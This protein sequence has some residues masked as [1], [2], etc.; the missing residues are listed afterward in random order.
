MDFNHTIFMKPTHLSLLFLIGFAFAV[1][2]QD[3]QG[4]P[5]D[6]SKPTVTDGAGSG[7]GEGLP[8]PMAIRFVPPPPPKPIPPIDVKAQSVKRLPSHRITV[9]RGEPSTLPDIPQL[10]PPAKAPVMMEFVS[11]PS[12]YLIPLSATIYNQSL[13]H[14]TWRNVKTGESFEA[15]CGW[16]FS[17]LAPMHTLKGQDAI[18]SLF[19]SPQHIDT[20]KPDRF[21]KRT[22]IP[23]HPLVPEED[24]ILIGGGGRS[25][26]GGELIEALQQFYHV[27]KTRLEQI[28]IARKQYRKES[29]AWHKANPRK[30]QDH[31]IWLKPH[32]G[33][34]YLAGGTGAGG[35][36]APET[37]T[38]EDAQ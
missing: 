19:F 4:P 8:D 2:A 24:Y 27:H 15:W 28:R 17:L 29:A 22:R 23:A 31:T 18:Y 35:E 9:L 7:A 13:S 38:G 10:T 37:T 20:T 30:P 11:Q 32:R 21:G 36:S 33:S 12:H 5:A 6:D 16:D 26:A 14:L 1:G 25:P 34:R 3:L